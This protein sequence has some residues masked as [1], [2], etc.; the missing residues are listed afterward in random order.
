MPEDLPELIKQVRK[1]KL[2]SEE[3]WDEIAQKYLEDFS[4]LDASEVFKRVDQLDMS[5]NPFISSEE[6]MNHRIARALEDERLRREGLNPEEWA[7]FHITQPEAGANTPLTD[8][9]ME[10]ISKKF[11]S[12][13]ELFVLQ[14]F[15]GTHTNPLT[16]NGGLIDHSWKIFIRVK[17]NELGEGQKAIEPSTTS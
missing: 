10:R 17:P 7:H 16:S 15:V 14:G 2:Y 3:E 4:G 6:R 11:P 1:E 13:I 5:A 8:K 9:D 12:G